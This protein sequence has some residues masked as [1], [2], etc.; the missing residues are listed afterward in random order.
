M[1]SDYSVILVDGDERTLKI[2]KTMLQK[3]GFGRVLGVT[4]LTECLAAVAEKP[5]PDMVV[6]DMVLADATGI[7]LLKAIRIAMT[8]LEADTPVLMI[9]TKP[10]P[11]QVSLARDYRLN[12]LLVKPFSQA[13]L[14]DRIE[15]CLRERITKARAEAVA[16]GMLLRPRAPLEP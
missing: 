12:G 11:H 5:R 4:S 6:S 14:A 16:R 2:E 13:Q 15:I 9:T 7:E 8:P 10:D 3:L 1:L